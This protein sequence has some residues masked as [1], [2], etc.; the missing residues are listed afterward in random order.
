MSVNKK[1]FEQLYDILP[2]LKVDESYQ[3]QLRHEEDLFFRPEVK[4]GVWGDY[5]SGKSSFLNALLGTD[6]LPVNIQ[7]TTAIVTELRY[8]KQEKMELVYDEATFSMTP[9]QEL[10]VYLLMNRGG[11]EELPPSL[12]N[13]LDQK[14]YDQQKAELEKVGIDESLPLRRVVF[15]RD[16]EILKAGNVFVDLP[17]LNASEDNA[18]IAINEINQCQIVLY[19]KQSYPAQFTKGDKEI[20]EL[21]SNK[22][23]GGFV[24][25]SVFTMM[26]LC[27]KNIRKENKECDLYEAVE[28]K[29]NEMNTA[30]GEYIEVDG[31]FITSSYMIEALKVSDYEDSAARDY[32]KTKYKNSFRF[33]KDHHSIKELCR[34]EEFEQRFYGEINSAQEVSRRKRLKSSILGLVSSIRSSVEQVEKALQT[35]KAQSAEMIG[36]WERELDELR[37][38]LRGLSDVR[39]NSQ[40]NIRKE[41]EAFLPKE[42]REWIDQAVRKT[43]SRGGYSDVDAINSAFTSNLESVLSS[44]MKSQKYKDSIKEIVENEMKSINEGV[45]S[46]HERINEVNEKYNVGNVD[47]DNETIV[48]FANGSNA[49]GVKIN[50]DA[51]NVGGAIDVLGGGGLGAFVAFEA[52]GEVVLESVIGDIFLGFGVITVIRGFFRGSKHGD[53]ATCIK[54]NFLNIFDSIFSFFGNERAEARIQIR[55]LSEVGG[56]KQFV[57]EIYDASCDKI[58]KDIS[59]SIVDKISE[60]IEDAKVF[61]LLETEINNSINVKEMQ[62]DSSLESFETRKAK[63]NEFYGY[64]DK[65]MN[66]VDE[67]EVLHVQKTKRAA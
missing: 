10:I 30:I 18:T 16:E 8:G 56:R 22:G 15:Y 17:G 65:F 47:L 32:L 26:D 61:K 33:L 7:E 64:R 24:V 31:S 43:T 6:V 45:L 20:L 29:L 51:F 23:K 11:F 1:F 46:L 4:I 35:E 36:K 40:S 41:I 14:K 2:K 59:S 39:K 28:S 19:F 9:N 55:K 42:Y 38:D 67:S 49:S 27:I 48:D 13:S 63:L 44:N 62:K 50:K 3:D 21:L 5:S 37:R 53:S 58:V 34:I 52:A 54:N 57:S 25:F 12:R 60:N 66:I